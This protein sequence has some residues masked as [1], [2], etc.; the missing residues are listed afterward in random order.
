MVYVQI[1]LKIRPANRE[2]DLSA[3]QGSL[4]RNDRGSALD[5]TARAR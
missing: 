4:S 1:T 2:A 5:G 3:L